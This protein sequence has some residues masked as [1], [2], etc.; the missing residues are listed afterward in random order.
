[1]ADTTARMV[2]AATDATGPAFKSA[3]LGLR[4]LS[5]AAGGIGAKFAGVAGTIGIATAAVVGL[6]AA[7]RGIVDGLDAFNDLSDATGASIDNLAALEDV[8]ARTG[9]S[10]E[11]VSQTLLKFNQAL[12]AAEP[13]SAQFEVFRR[14]GLDVE[15]LKRADPVQ[16]LAQTAQALDR[17]SADGAKARAEQELF[18]KS[19]GKVAPLL[20]DL[21][22][23]GELGARSLSSA[24]DEAEKFNK[25]LASITKN[26]T[27]AARGIVADV[28]PALNEMFVRLSAAR[29]T[30]GGLGKSF[31]AGLNTQQFTN[32]AEGVEFFTKKLAELDRQRAETLESNKRRGLGILGQQDY[33]EERG[34]I[35]KLLD[36]YTRVAAKTGQL[37]AGAGRGVVN[38]EPAAPSIGEGKKAKKAERDFED[39]SQQITQSLARMI[40]DTDLV[41]VATLNAQLK[42]LDELA[43]AGLDPKIVADVRAL[44]QPL[45]SV[46]EL[47]PAVSQDTLDRYKALNDLLEQTPTAKLERQRV[48]L[49]DLANAYERGR[50]GAIG[51][52]DAMKK[53][54]EAAQTALGGIPDEIEKIDSFAEQASRNIQDSLGDTLTKVLDGDFKSIGS[55]WA[56]TVKRMVAEAA[57][58]KL[59]TYLFGSG[60]FSGEGVLGGL[61]S[62][63]GSLLGIGKRADG[64]PVSAGSP[65]LVGERGPELIVPSSA[66]TV[67]PNGAL[68]GVTVVQNNTFG[69]N[70]SRAEVGALLAQQKA[71]TIATIQQM[72]ARGQL[73]AV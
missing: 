67:I 64:G 31:F 69:S 28:L 21:A 50:F 15:A 1:M 27:D 55:L 54:G 36:F 19:L 46:D 29:E 62:G 68:G 9:T 51:S 26:A 41:K 65:Y 20:K 10:F 57:A 60:V 22:E 37:G 53:F 18:G 17:F 25:H 16:A 4:G 14:L 5:E 12:Q 52:A 47:F 73:G 48:L 32:A 13:G 35:E 30:F 72:M 58:A 45:G 23:N 49:Q 44:L 38:P 33:Q 42:R 7:F 63:F 8:A 6:A 3:S 24:A 43:A 59:N 71:A 66:G 40:E 61:F 39:Y 2:I 11:T 56:N 70:I 34:R